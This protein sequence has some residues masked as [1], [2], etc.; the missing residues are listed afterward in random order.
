MISSVAVYGYGRYIRVLRSYV[1]IARHG[2]FPRARLGKQKQH[3]KTEITAEQTKLYEIVD[4]FLLTQKKSLRLVRSKQK[5][6]TPLRGAMGELDGSLSE[7]HYERRQPMGF[8]IGEGG[9]FWDDGITV[10]VGGEGGR[11]GHISEAAETGFLDEGSS[12][13]LLIGLSS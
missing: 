4:L 12:S 13:S 3:R 11:G 7:G 8:R 1:K 5:H 9:A 6:V 2:I 10:L